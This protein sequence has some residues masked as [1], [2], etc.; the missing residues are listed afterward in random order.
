[1]LFVAHETLL[2]RPPAGA[3]DGVPE[4]VHLERAASM[5][6]RGSREKLARY[7]LPEPVEYLL[8]WFRELAATRRVGMT[9][10]EP[11]S[12]ADI[13]AWARQTRRTPTSEEVQALIRLDGA[14][15][16]PEAILT[17][18]SDG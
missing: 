9:G 4:R 18:V 16:D 3:K 7:E 14:S 15:R 13:D 8:E 12:Y 6:H 5:G 2:S 10:T 1:M 11:L 17:E